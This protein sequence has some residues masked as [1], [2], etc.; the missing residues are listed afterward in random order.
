MS[1]NNGDRVQ[2]IGNGP[3]LVGIVQYKIEIPPPR[4]DPDGETQI[5]Y[6][7][8]FPTIGTHSI[9]DEQSLKNA[10]NPLI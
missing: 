5:S 2:K 8:S 10:V 9:V 1:F 3:S 4:W 6:S 7:V